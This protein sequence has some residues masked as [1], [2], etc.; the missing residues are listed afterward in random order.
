MSLSNH[1]AAKRLQIKDCSVDYMSLTFLTAAP[2]HDLTHSWTMMD[3]RCCMMSLI[4]EA[5]EGSAGHSWN[6]LEHFSTW[7]A[8][9]THHTY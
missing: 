7:T 2:R 3:Q 5:D 8:P 6:A 4:L 1:L 9:I